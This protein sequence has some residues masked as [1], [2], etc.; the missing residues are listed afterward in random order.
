MHG[1]TVK[2]TNAYKFVLENA[3]VRD[4][5][6]GVDVDGRIILKQT[7]NKEDRRAWGGFFWLRTREY[8]GRFEWGNDYL[9]L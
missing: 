7:L 4:R 1:E 3:K 8:G 6:E 9:I 2:F 5:L